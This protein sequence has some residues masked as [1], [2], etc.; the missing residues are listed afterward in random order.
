M[1]KRV[2]ALREARHL[3]NYTRC[4]VD[5]ITGKSEIGTGMAESFWRS[6][7]QQSCRDIKAGCLDAFP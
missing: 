7:T 6:A 5:I 3:V 1:L 2:P 4:Y